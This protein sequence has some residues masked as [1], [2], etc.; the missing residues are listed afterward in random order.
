[1][2]A[3]ER[4]L[5]SNVAFKKKAFK[6]TTEETDQIYLNHKEIKQLADKNL[7]ERLKRV[8]DAFVINCYLGMRFSDLSQIKKDN[9]TKNDGLYY[10]N[11]VQGKTNE[12]ISI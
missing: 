11:M 3:L 7:S 12:K 10:L 8:A 1:T 2:A 9:F 5:H 4:D 6:T